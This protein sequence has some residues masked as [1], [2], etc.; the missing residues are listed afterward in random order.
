M[1]DQYNRQLCAASINVASR[2]ASVNGSGVDLQGYEAATA[3]VNVGAWAG[4]QGT[5]AIKLQDS[6]DNSTFTDVAAGYLVGDNPTMSGYINRAGGAGLEQGYTGGNRYLRA[7]ATLTGGGTGCV[8]GVIIVRG[9]KRH[10]PS[11]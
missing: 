9:L 3:I 10:G 5:W 6:T 1:K 8:F 7:V 4:N 2:T 11:H